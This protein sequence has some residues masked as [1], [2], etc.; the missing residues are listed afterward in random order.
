VRRIA[1]K[2]PGGERLSSWHFSGVHVMSPAVFDFMA[3]EG[4]DDIIAVYLRMIE[5]G[6]VVRGAV[7]SAY[8]SDLGMPSR[9]LATQRDLLFR[10][11]PL[12]L[13]GDLS[14][15]APVQPGTGNYWSAPGA[16]VEGAV[17]GPAYFAAG[18]RVD[19][20]AQIGSA[21]YLGPNSR[22][23]AGARLNRVTVLDDTEIAP[24]EELVEVI[25]WKHHRIPAPLGSG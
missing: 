11:V 10:Q 22:V 15:F 13:L 24:G 21:V 20:G 18:S 5:Q 23:A 2:G 1:G 14:P 3:P 19:R 4:P 12:E 7:A 25:A 9:Y 16:Q 8:W 6:V 17:A